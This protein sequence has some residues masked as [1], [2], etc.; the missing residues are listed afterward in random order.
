MYDLCDTCIERH[1]VAMEAL[2]YLRVSHQ[3]GTFQVIVVERMGGGEGGSLS[4]Q[5]KSA[6]VVH[7]PCSG[8]PQTYG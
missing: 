6:A 1:F 5:C 4:L 3:Y 7:V 8:Y 2:S